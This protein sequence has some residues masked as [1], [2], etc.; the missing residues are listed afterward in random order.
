M[1][2]M[3]YTDSDISIGASQV[4]AV[5]GFSPYETP[6]SIWRKIV[7]LEPTATE[8]P[9]ST[10]RKRLG[11]LLEDD[12]LDLFEKETGRVVVTK[13]PDTKK[14]KGFIH[15]TPDG[16][17][18]DGSL[19]EIKTSSD[20][21]WEEVPYHYYIQVQIQMYVHERD[22][23]YIPALCSMNYHCYVVDYNE[24]DAIR[25]VEQAKWFYDTYVLPRI[26][27]P[28]S[29]TRVLRKSEELSTVEATEKIIELAQR[30]RELKE[31][32]LEIIDKLNALRQ[33]IKKLLPPRTR[34]VDKEGNVVVSRSVATVRPSINQQALR[35]Y[36]PDVFY[37]VAG[38]PRTIERIVVR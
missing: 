37:Q 25:F 13:Q 30:Y 6:Q 22:K 34:A 4:A 38:E 9:L 27:P 17:A 24:R 10:F 3:S 23:T 14:R 1:N 2:L 32:E 29:L 12:V 20:S 16:I 11:N 7:G 19:V 36:Y 5:L 8:S 35:E 26:E 31:A 33:E 15:A 18:D 21:L 28:P